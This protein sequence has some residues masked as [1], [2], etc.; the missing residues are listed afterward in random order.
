MRAPAW[1]PGR[2]TNALVGGLIALLWC[3]GE[4]AA[5]LRIAPS[6]IV[7]QGKP[8]QSLSGVYTL[9]N[10]GDAPVDI[11]VE[12]EDWSGG[13]QGARGSVPWFRIKP[14]S[15]TVRPG[16]TARVKFSVRIPKDASGEIRTQVFFTTVQGVSEEG[17]VP[18]RSRQGVVVYVGIEGTQQLD[19]AIEGVKVFYAASTPGVSAPDRLELVFQVHNRSNTHIVPDGHVVVRNAEGNVV[20]RLKVQSGWGLVP[21]EQDTYRAIGSGVHLQPGPV[22]IELTLTYGSDFGKPQSRTKTVGAVIDE[23]RSIR[24][25]PPAAP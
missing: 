9:E 11:M 24:L 21:N 2:W 6:R 13:I 23:D 19:A 16:K 4:A 12:P 20:A 1:K 18:L 14:T 7:L 5:G 15:L 22:T 3:C 25:L 8:G 17:A 10:T